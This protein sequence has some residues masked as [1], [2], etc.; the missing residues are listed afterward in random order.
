MIVLVMILSGCGKHDKVS[1]PDTEKAKITA[2]VADEKNPSVKSAETVNTEQYTD[3]N[4]KLEFGSVK[5]RDFIVDNLLH[6]ERHGDIHFSVY[7]PES[8]DGG[9]PY[10]LFIT[11]PGWEGLYF[12]GTGA[13]LVEDFPF[14]AKKYNDKM[15]II[16]PQLD[17]WGETSADM[18]IALTEYFLENYNIDKDKVYLHGMSGGGETGSIVMGKSPE[19]YTAY[20]ETSSKW[21][22]DIETLVKA[23]TPVYMVIGEFD[24]YYGAEPMKDA[25]DEIY[26][27]YKDGGLSDEKIEKLLVLDVR[28]SEYFS[29][30][31]YSDQHAGGQAFAHDEEIMGW[32][33][34]E[35]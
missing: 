7:I 26:K 32:L 29:D 4:D 20:L 9:S 22:G 33:F 2:K 17:D 15:I 10:A 5:D 21:D 24:S 13:N 1:V 8:Y 3:K 28:E 19:L 30:R 18:T 31:G 27:S 16:S 12:Q 25:Y 11:L 23:K 35:H 14:E 34:S 6:S